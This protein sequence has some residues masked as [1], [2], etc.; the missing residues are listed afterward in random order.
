MRHRVTLAL[1]ALATG[2]GGDAIAQTSR[3]LYTQDFDSLLPALGASVNERQ[4]AESFDYVTGVESTPNTQATPSAFSKTGPAGWVVDNTIGTY[5]GAPTVGNTGVPGQ[6]LPDYGVDEWEGWSFANKNFWF[7]KDNQRR[8]EF[9]KASGTIAVVDPDEYYDLGGEDDPVNGGFYNSGLKT[10]P[11]AVDGT[12][13]FQLRFDSSW[14]DEEF[15]DDHKDPAFNRLNNQSVEIYAKLS[16]GVVMP[17]TDWNSNETTPSPRF[18]ND[19]TNESLSFD[20]FT[21]DPSV[22]SVEFYFNMANAANDWWWAI[23]N[24]EVSNINPLDGTVGPAVYTEGFETVAL[25]PSVNERRSTIATIPR[26]TAANNDPATTPRPGSFT[27]TEPAGWTVDNTGTPALGDD[28]VGVYEWEGWSFATP[29]F[30]TF[31]DKQGREAFAGGTGVVAI[32][33]GDEWDDL[34]NPDADDTVSLKSLMTSDLIDISGLAPGEMLELQFNSSWRAEDDQTAIVEVDFGFGPVPLLTWLS[35]SSSPM[36]HGD[37]TN[38]LVTLSLD[39][40]GAPTVRISF[41]YSGEDDWWW[42]IDNVRVN[43]V[44]IPE[45]SAALLLLAAAPLARRRN[46]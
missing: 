14:R 41:R 4:G 15:D 42:A 6:G 2:L 25:G 34:G 46:R 20:V 12:A 24:V 13:G 29:E 9:T 38:E 16:N 39:P 7:E 19:A 36:F 35:D 43:A 10:A 1:I 45:P 37:N 30:W 31:A 40:Q 8:S 3:N 44:S 33:D 5:L 21:A 11:I 26:L 23:D 32:A 17:I 27:N 28:N 18:K 22:T